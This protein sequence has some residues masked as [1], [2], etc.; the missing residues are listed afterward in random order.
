[1]TSNNGNWTAADI[2]DQQG[3]V[4]IITGGNSGIGYEAARALAPKGATIVLAVRSNEK[5]EHAADAIRRETPQADIHVMHLDLANLASVEAFAGAFQAAYSRLDVLINNAGVMAIPQ[6]HTAD[7]FEMQFGT[8]HLGHYALTGHLLELLLDTPDAR[9]VT[10]SSNLHRSATMQFDDLHHEAN[11]TR[12]GPYNQSKLANLLFTF[13]L[14]R[15]INAAGAA[16]ISVACHP[17]YA[18]TNLQNAGP[19]MDG[20]AASKV[21]MQI[22][23]TLFA[24][25]AAMGALPTLYAATALDVNGCDYIGPDGFMR[26]RGYPVK[27]PAKDTAY[28]EPDAA[29]L[30][31]I[32]EEWTGITYA[33]LEPATA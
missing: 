33:A 14:Q 32:S 22:A 26:M 10:V 17:G 11:Y 28:N 1:M 2:P 4:F 8:N 3:R 15:K 20:S 13:E 23:N 5:G 6:R 24:Q 16:L 19:N 7:G 30:W 29:R 9:V 31:A 18:A 21:M 25:D 27:E 12:Y